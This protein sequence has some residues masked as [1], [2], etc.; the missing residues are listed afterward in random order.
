MTTKQE[1]EAALAKAKADDDRAVASL[2]ATN[3]RLTALAAR[4]RAEDALAGLPRAAGEGTAP[5]LERRKLGED[6]RKAVSD[7]AKAVEDRCREAADR[8]GGRGQECF[9]S[10]YAL[11]RA[12]EQR[13][14][15][16]GAGVYQQAYDRCVA[17]R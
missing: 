2:D 12:R 8:D 16:Q 3:T 11:S 14:P 4:N 5:A 6:R 9:E 13:A 1:L 17:R 10:A 15:G 7:W